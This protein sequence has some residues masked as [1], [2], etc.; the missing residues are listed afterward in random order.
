[1]KRVFVVGLDALSPK[2]V[3]RFANEGICPNFKWIMDNGGFSKVLSAIPA[4][5]PEN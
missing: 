5:T 3:E 2:L 1:M 4:Q